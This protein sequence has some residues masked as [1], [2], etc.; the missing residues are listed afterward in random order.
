MRFFLFPTLKIL[1]QF[2][3]IKLN[4]E[5]AAGLLRGNFLILT[6][7]V[8]FRKIQVLGRKTSYTVCIRNAEN[9]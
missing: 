7:V 2:A 5:K 6:E 1:R 8:Y 9:L 4:D 3:I